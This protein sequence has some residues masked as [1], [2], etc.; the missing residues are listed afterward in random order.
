VIVDGREIL[1][2]WDNTIRRRDNTIHLGG[3]T[4]RSASPSKSALAIVRQDAEIQ[5]IRDHLSRILFG[6]EAADTFAG[7]GKRLQDLCEEFPTLSAVRGSRLPT[8]HKLAIVH[9]IAPAYFAMI[10]QSVRER[11]PQIADV[12][13]DRLTRGR[14][15]DVPALRVL[16]HGT[17][18]WQSELGGTSGLTI[19]SER[20]QAV[21]NLA[22]V[23]LWPDNAVILID[24]FET[25]L[26]TY[27]LEPVMAAAADQD[28]NLQVILTSAD[29]DVLQRIGRDRR[30]V[31]VWQGS[32]V[33]IDDNPEHS[34]E[35]ARGTDIAVAPGIVERWQQAHNKTAITAGRAAE[36]RAT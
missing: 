32:I 20:L 3:H 27:C 5:A 8:Y 36:S 25:S 18:Q 6:E 16:E 10:V 28:R 13:F 24:D 30:K 35:Q 12:D 31:V 15:T 2:R 9:E 14:F 7:L 1:R 22:S 11:F 26:G 34:A 19:S 33:T 21:L 4:L 23:A 29:P 17:D